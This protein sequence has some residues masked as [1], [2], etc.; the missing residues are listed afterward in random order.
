MDIGAAVFSLIDPFTRSNTGIITLG[1]LLAA[2]LTLIFMAPYLDRLGVNVPSGSRRT[3]R[4]LMRQIGKVRPRSDRG[5]TSLMADNLFRGGSPDD[6]VDTSRE[7][8]WAVRAVSG[9]VFAAF[10]VVLFLTTGEM[11][12][13]AL[14][15]F[16]YFVPSGLAWFHNRSRMAKIKK[17]LPNALPKMAVQFSSA[18]NLGQ[19][20]ER[21]ALEGDGPLYAEFAR[22]GHEM[23][24]ATQAKW[25]EY[26]RGIDDRNPGLYFFSTL[27]DE[28]EREYHGSWAKLQEAALD[29]LTRAIDEHYALMSARLGSLQNKFLVAFAPFFFFAFLLVMIGPILIHALMTAGGTKP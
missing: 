28:I 23:T 27:A 25:L 24:A 11:A 10:G 2:L 14:A 17:A 18:Y 4:R 5:F 9:L 6:M 15:A 8:F 26:L 21:L 12:Y 13:V 20:F 16:G 1:L 3:D 29:F 19:V 22:T 7:F